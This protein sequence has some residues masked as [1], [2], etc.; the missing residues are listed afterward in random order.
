M[1]SDFLNE[2]GV[3]PEDLAARSKALE[4]LDSGDRVLRN[5][6]TAARRLKKTYEE[7]DAKKPGSLGRGV[8]LR[9]INFALEGQP[10]TRLNRKK[11]ARAVNSLL[12]SS[13]KEEIDWRKLF[14]DTP[15]RKGKKK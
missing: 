7:S 3:K 14:T 1:L 6:R 8:T 2:N 13:K 11:I 10:I 15:S 9:V 5:K 12:K 4:T